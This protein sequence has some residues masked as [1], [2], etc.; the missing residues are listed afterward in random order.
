MRIAVR[1]FGLREQCA[2][3]GEFYKDREVGRRRLLGG[4]VL[5]GFERADANLVG[6]HLAVVEIATVA[7]DR[8]VDIELVFKAG[9]IVVG[10]MARRGV[11]GTGAAVGGH[12]IGQNDRGR[13]VDERMAGLE[14]LQSGTFKR[15]RE[16]S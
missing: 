13:A 14:T 6:G 7:A 11:D 4:D 3:T 10:A 5:D 2:G 15:V 8:A 1:V 9:E 12:V 16:C